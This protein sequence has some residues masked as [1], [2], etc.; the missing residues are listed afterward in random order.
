M[1]DVPRLCSPLCTA[2]FQACYFARWAVAGRASYAY[3]RILIDIG[4]GRMKAAGCRR[5]CTVTPGMESV[6][7]WLFDGAYAT[8]PETNATF[9][10]ADLGALRVWDFSSPL[11]PPSTTENGW[12]GGLDANASNASIAPT[13]VCSRECE[14][15]FLG[16]QYFHHESHSTCRNRLN[17]LTGA[18]GHND[19]VPFCADTTAMAAS[20]TSP[21]LPPL[22]PPS[23]PLSPLS[24]ATH[25][26][27]VVGVT[28]TAALVGIAL[29]AVAFT[30]VAA[31]AAWRLWRHKR[32]GNVGG[33]R[34]STELRFIDVVA[35][36]LDRPT[37]VPVATNDLSPP[38]NQGAADSRTLHLVKGLAHSAL[39]SAHMIS[40]RLGP[41]QKNLSH[42]EEQEAR[43]L[44]TTQALALQ[45]VVDACAMQSTFASLEEGKYVTTLV[46]TDVGQ[47]TAS[48]RLPKNHMVVHVETT[49]STSSSSEDSSS[50]ASGY[51]PPVL[52]VRVD[53]A[54]LRIVINEAIGNCLKYREPET[55]IVLK[56][57]FHERGE[58]E[59]AHLD[60][61]I[62]NQNAA[63]A[64]CL[65]AD[66][67]KHLFEKGFKGANATSTSTGLGL[68]TA[69][70]AATAAGGKLRLFGFV[71][72]EGLSYTALNVRFPAEAMPP[73]SGAPPPSAA[74]AP[75]T[76]SG[77]GPSSVLAIPAAEPDVELLRGLVF[78]SLQISDSP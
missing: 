66:E 21:P 16:C 19:C 5:R 3:C 44:A 68:S 78:Q 49:M 55:P 46:E 50:S 12:G 10:Q 35:K 60:V 27:S 71:D 25:P 59:A 45:E 43:S 7:T 62:E 63:E 51:I 56:M 34:T 31:G 6:R 42:S 39:M 9:T 24:N 36:P 18:F 76:A 70:T 28:D 75:L 4:N 8:D 1:S 22:L 23:P 37:S 64:P 53:S 29:G 41:E 48:M 17:N 65:T 54:L 58:V 38:A 69:M 74:P 77:P 11:A 40:S 67:Y 13:P 33:A 30:L 26:T 2:E 52:M 57:S 73:P 20:A 47:L 14:G 61:Q 32:A 72:A 15:V